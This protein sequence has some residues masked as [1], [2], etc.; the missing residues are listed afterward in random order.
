MWII[1]KEAYRY[2]WVACISKDRTYLLHSR[3][4]LKTD[5]T[6]MLFIEDI[7]ASTLTRAVLEPIVQVPTEASAVQEG[8][9]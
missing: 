1:G 3:Y 7:R 4:S 6:L 8:A 2:I 9:N 5:T